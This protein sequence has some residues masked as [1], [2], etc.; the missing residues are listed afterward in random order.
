MVH[1]FLQVQNMTGKLR[2]EV[3]D[4]QGCFIFPETWFGSLLMSLKNWLMHTMRMKSA[5]QVT[6]TNSGALPDRRMTLLMYT[7]TWHTYFWSRMPR[8]RRWMLPLKGW[9]LAIVLSLKVSVA[10]SSGYILTTDLFFVPSMRQSWQM[11]IYSVIRMPSCSLKKYWITIPKIIM[12]HAGYWDRNC[13]A[14]ALMNRH[15]IY[16]RNMQMN[17]HLTGMNSAFCI[18]LWGTGK[19]CNCISSRLCGKYLHRRNTVRKSASISTC[20]MA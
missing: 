6:S 7:L 4:N 15:A 10:E 20:C 11:H 14:L 17:F 3:N 18:F 5:K 8:V 16:C 12:V 2:F 19:S 9:Q 13:Y 1:P